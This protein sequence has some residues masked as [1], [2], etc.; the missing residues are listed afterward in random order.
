MQKETKPVSADLDFE[1]VTP[2][3][4]FYLLMRVQPASVEEI[5][6]YVRSIPGVTLNTVMDYMQTDPMQKFSPAGEGNWRLTG[7]VETS[8]AA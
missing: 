5:Y 8:R 1:E 2:L 4:E 6:Q 7:W 3:I